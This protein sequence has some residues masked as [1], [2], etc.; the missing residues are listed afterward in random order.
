MELSTQLRVWAQQHL[1]A[2]FLCRLSNEK[3]REMLRD[4]F[5]ETAKS[6]KADFGIER[7]IQRVLNNITRGMRDFRR[8]ADGCTR[9]ALQS[10]MKDSGLAH[11]ELFITSP[12]YIEQMAFVTG[13]KEM[14]A[15][16]EIKRYLRS[17]NFPAL[18]EEFLRY[19][20]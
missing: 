20:D 17:G 5:V 12:V 7:I 6:R 3:D 9:A 4:C 19:Q 13:L 2:Q 14:F 1:F 16:D 10:A 15:R 18:R 11:L 8:S